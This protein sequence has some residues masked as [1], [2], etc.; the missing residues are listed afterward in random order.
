[1][2]HF[3]VLVHYNLPRWGVFLVGLFVL[4]ANIMLGISSSEETDLGTL[5]NLR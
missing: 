5:T 2:V 4:K 3:M 1:M